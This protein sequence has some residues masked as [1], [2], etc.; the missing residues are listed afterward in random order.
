LQL[1]ANSIQTT[2]VELERKR[3]AVELHDDILNRL[4][5]QFELKKQNYLLFY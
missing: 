4:S 1:N 2:A 3:I 5:I